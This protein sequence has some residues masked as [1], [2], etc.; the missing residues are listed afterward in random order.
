MRSTKVTI[1]SLT[2]IIAIS[3]M[4][5]CG[6][7]STSDTSATITE[8][9]PGK[10]I[11]LDMDTL[12]DN[13]DMG[14]LGFA[15][16][17]MNAGRLNILAVV[18]SGSDWTQR[19]SIATSAVNTFYNRELKI[20]Y[21]HRTDLRWHYSPWAVSTPK[22]ETQYNGTATD[23]S[24]FAS[25]GISNNQRPSSVSVY[26]D[27][28]QTLPAGE[29]ATVVIT[30]QVYSF[31]DLL[32]ETELCNGRQLIIDKVDQVLMSSED[33][34]TV[35]MNFSAG[36]DTRRLPDGQ[37]VWAS[38]ADDSRYTL[39]N[40]PVEYILFNKPAITYEIMSGTEYQNQ[41]IDSPMAFIYATNYNGLSAGRPIW[42]H[43]PIMYA[44]S[45]NNWD[46][47]QL[48]HIH[49]EHTLYIDSSGRVQ[50]GS[51]SEL[52]HG[53]ADSIGQEALISQIVSTFMFN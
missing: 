39:A 36:G 43:L 13:D 7:S 11:I 23:I 48:F 26:C 19:N 42:D 28:L 22:L 50:K 34:N 16:G 40:I 24:H 33:F 4:T 47:T 12:T 29:K 27:I 6:S 35:G 9:I 49:K 15:H 38:T 5:A 10:K 2:M 37:F 46:G 41:L 52:D 18:Q 1:Y 3:I 53:W 30:G 20:G 21:N 32:K 51:G 45:G 25:D 17:L 44:A 31:V 8:S 14:A